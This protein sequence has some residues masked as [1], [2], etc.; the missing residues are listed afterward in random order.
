MFR[1]LYEKIG[2]SKKMVLATSFEDRVTARTMSVIFIDGNFYF[3]TDENFLKYEQLIKNPR[4]AL[5]YD[6]VQIEG[7]AQV[8]GSPQDNEKFVEV[9]SKDFKKSY[10][11][12]S[13][14]ESEKLIVVKPTFITVWSYR[15]TQAV[16]EFYDCE[17]RVYSEKLYK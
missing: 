10:E 8:L 1:K 9:F 14:L 15:G 3:Q 7:I 16:R 13:H 5:C 4:V 17:N 6:N 11:A 2:E 12:Y